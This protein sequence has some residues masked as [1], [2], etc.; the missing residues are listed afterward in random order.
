MCEAKL[1]LCLIIDSSGSVRDNN[2]LDGSDN[3]Q[4]QLEFF[5]NLLEGFSIGQ[6][7]TRVAA[8]VFSEQ[9][10]LG[11]PTEQVQQPF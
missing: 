8:I 1:D 4:L 11:V 6:N 5:S 2:P 10:D 3:W 7:D 9:V